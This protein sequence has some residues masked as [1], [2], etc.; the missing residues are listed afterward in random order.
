[1]ESFINSKFKFYKYG[2][3]S[4][5]LSVYDIQTVGHTY[6]T[7]FYNEND[8]PYFHLLF[9]NILINLYDVKLVP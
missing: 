7:T 3:N 8:I 5:A 1:M 6:L 9:G 2:W 4:Y